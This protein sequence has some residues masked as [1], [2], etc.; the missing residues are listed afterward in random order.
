M[1]LPDRRSACHIDNMLYSQLLEKSYCLYALMA[2]LTDYEDLFVLW[3]LVPSLLERVY[4]KD[5][6]SAQ[7]RSLGLK[8]TQ[9]AQTNTLFTPVI[10][11]IICPCLY[12]YRCPHC[13]KLFEQLVSFYDRA[14]NTCLRFWHNSVGL[15]D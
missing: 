14:S 11:A 13:K 7:A 5:R 3:N 6:F 12:E 4:I 15:D 2:T 9:E 1:H 10:E 8:N